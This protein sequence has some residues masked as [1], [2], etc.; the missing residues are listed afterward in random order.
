MGFLNEIWRLIAGHNALSTFFYMFLTASAINVFLA[1]F[2]RSRKIQPKGFK[3]K[4]YRNEIAFG[5]INVF[6]S[7]LLIGGG[8]AFLTSHGLI[9]V[10]TAP[11]SWW[12]IALEYG[13][14]FIAYDTWFYWMHRL[15]HKEPVYT[16]VH[17]IHHKSTSPNLLTTFSVGPLESVVNGGF[18]PLFTAVVTVHSQSLALMT[19]SAGL[20]GIYIHSGY[21]FMPRWWNRTWATKWF[22]TATFHDQHHKYFNW[23]YGGYTTIWDRICGTTRKKYEADFVKLKDRAASA[24]AGESGASGQI[25]TGQPAAGQLEPV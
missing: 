15:M 18:I 13:F 10:N 16:L 17:K 5:L 23:N 7:G 1:V 19:L 14:Y 3:W 20:I 21:E 12:I 8:T 6:T 22:I 4:T 24:K 11:A 9:K 25:S 2:F